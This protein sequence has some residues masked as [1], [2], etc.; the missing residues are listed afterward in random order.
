VKIALAESRLSAKC[1]ARILS[2]ILAG[3]LSQDD[4]IAFGPLTGGLLENARHYNRNTSETGIQGDQRFQ[5][6][7]DYEE[8]LL[9]ENLK[10][11][12]TPHCRRA[13]W[14]IGRL[15]HSWQ[16]FF[17]HAIRRD[18]RGG[19]ENSSCPGWTAWSNG[20]NGDPSNRANFWPSSFSMPNGGEHPGW[21]KEPLVDCS[22][23][24]DARYAAAQDYTTARI[25]I[26]LQ[27]WV[28]S[29]NC[30]CEDSWDISWY[31]TEFPFR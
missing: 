31:T 1:K 30:A 6:Y 3:N 24:Y 25:R 11:P 12:S 17:M 26:L 19:R 5:N 10:K 22:P 15:S 4:P 28:S 14:S 2:A 20:V 13:L 27:Q 18:G 7:I 21:G 23:E 16:D 9:S 8:K 29:C